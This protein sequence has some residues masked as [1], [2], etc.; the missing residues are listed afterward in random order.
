MFSRLRVDVHV[1]THIRIRYRLEYDI[2]VP[3]HS[4]GTWGISEKR[5]PQSL[6]LGATFSTCGDPRRTDIPANVVNYKVAAGLGSYAH[7][8]PLGVA[9]LLLRSRPKP[10]APGR[11]GLHP[12]NRCS[13][14]ALPRTQPLSQ[15]PSAAGTP[16][17][18]HV[19]ESRE[20]PC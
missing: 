13:A 7:G 8:C 17:P 20:G 15:G 16:G 1:I 10:V 6:P 9:P 3:G 11:R 2:Q 14:G 4:K 19:S 5:S 12:A 18:H